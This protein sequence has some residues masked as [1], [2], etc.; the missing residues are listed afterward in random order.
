MTHASSVP[1]LPCPHYTQPSGPLQLCLHP[2]PAPLTF[3]YPLFPKTCARPCSF[4]LTH[5]LFA[6]SCKSNN[7]VL[8]IAFMFI[9]PIRLVVNIYITFSTILWVTHSYLD[10]SW[11]IILLFYNWSLIERNDLEERFFMIKQS[12]TE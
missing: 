10:L 12:A 2:A 9:F 4:P 7:N 1:P 11:I 8:S 5:H 6:L 3:L